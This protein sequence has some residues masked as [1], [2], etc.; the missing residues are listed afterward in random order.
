MLKNYHCKHGSDGAHKFYQHLGMHRSSDKPTTKS[1]I[2][3]VCFVL[4][5][6]LHSC[7]PPIIH[8]NLT[9]DTIFIQ[10]N[11]LVKIGSVAPDAINHHVKTCRENIKNMHFIAPEYG[12][13]AVN[14]I[15]SSL[16]PAI[17]IFSFGMCALEMAALEIQGNGDSGTMVT[18]ENILRTIESIE[19]GQQKDFISKCLSHDPAERPSAK[20]LLFHPLL[21]EVHSLKLLVAHCLLNTARKIDMFMPLSRDIN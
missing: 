3:F 21:F 6:Y 14:S 19:D 20:E 9:C 2:N 7:T 5:S 17:D 1:I 11:G 13:V 10:H 12:A 18:Q 8:G 4:Y 16:T 15:A